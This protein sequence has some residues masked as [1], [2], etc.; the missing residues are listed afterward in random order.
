MASGNGGTT[1]RAD[2]L[3][4]I[5]GAYFVA[6]EEGRAPSREELL[7]QHPDLAAELADYFG[8]QDRL[9]R[10]VA[11][12]R[13][14]GEPASTALDSLTLDLATVPHVL[15]RD[16]EPVS[17]GDP[18]LQPL[19]PEMP[20]LA[21][22][23][24]RLQLFGEIA[25]GG[26][27]AILKGRDVD[28]GREL[29]VKVLLEAH[30]GNP[31]IVRRFVEEAQI[32]G[33]LQHPGDRPRLRAR[34]LRRPPAL[35]RHEAGQGADAGQP[36]GRANPSP[37]GRRCPQG[38]MRVDVPPCEAA[39]TPTHSRWERE[40]VPTSPASCPSSSRSARRWPTPTPGA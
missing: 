26:M 34:H 10:M 30:Q 29:A 17:D 4:E 33:Q 32:G 14:P 37:A 6:V 38:R 28:L 16:T 7:A 20:A 12:L 24:A 1:A 27:G 36:A 31:E 19:S 3:G 39:L 15:L 22:R 13:P 40:T 9:D 23:P 25:R 8:E 18:L 35:F 2:R 21:D 11:P 5:L